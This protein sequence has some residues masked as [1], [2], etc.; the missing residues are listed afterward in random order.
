[1][2]DKASRQKN[3]RFRVPLCAAGVV[4][5]V[6]LLLPLSHDVAQAAPGDVALVSATASGGSGDDVSTRPSVSADGRYVAFESKASELLVPNTTGDQIFRKD[7]LSGEIVLVSCNASGVQGNANSSFCDISA[8]GRYVAFESDASNLVSP[9][10]C[11]RQVFRK[12]LATGEIKL[13]SCNLAGFSGNAD[14][15]SAS[16]SGDGRYVAFESDA[17]NLVTPATSGCQI[18]R[19][20]MLTGEVS[21]CSSDAYGAQGDGASFVPEVNADGRY[22]AFESDSTNLVTPTTSGRQ[23][24]RK[25]LQTG[26]AMLASC[27]M[28][29][30]QGDSASFW[31][32]ISGDGRFLAFTSLSTNLVSPPSAFRQI[33]RKDMETGEI[34]RA[35]CDAA[36]TPG[37]GDSNDASLSFDGRFA[38]FESYATNLAGGDAGINDV[39]RKDM[40]TGTVELCSANAAEQAANGA[41]FVADISGDGR[42]TAFSSHA[43]NLVSPLATGQQV[44]R[45]ELLAPTT[46]YFAEGYTGAGFQEYLCLGQPVD[47][48][49][50]VTVT[51]LFRDG[52]TRQETY[53]VPALSRFTVNV[54]GVVGA[55]ME[56]SLKCEAEFPFIA[57]RPM[58]F[59]YGG[60]G[61]HWTGGHDVMGASGSSYAWY[62]AEG[63]TGAGFDEW[64]CVLNPG[65]TAADLTFRFQTQE[66]GEKTVAGFSVP[67]HSRGSFKANDLLEGK[68]YQTSLKLES[69]QPVVAERPMYFAYSGTAG[70][71][72]TGVS[73][74][75]G[76][77]SLS[78]TYFFAEGTTRDGFEEWLTLQNPGSADINVHA[79]YQLGDGAPVEKDYHVPAGRRSTILVNSPE[80]GVGADKDVSVALTCP[81]PFLA[82]RPMYFDY[83][84]LGNWGWTGG[85]CVI[86]AP[87]H[88]T[89]WY[90]AEGYTGQGFEEWIC[91]QN[92]GTS[93]ADVTVTYYKQGGGAPIVKAQPP[94]PP[95]SRYTVP[96]NRDAGD[97]LAISAEVSSNQPIIAERPM[98]FNYDGKWSGGHDVVGYTP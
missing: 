7:L 59:D 75:M 63:Y 8:D 13:A 51:Y 35:S 64:V 46:F 44:Y 34:R 80:V 27:T 68:S 61:A 20:D 97:D 86:G 28:A 70:H 71:G 94:I 4:L 21:L 85:H 11:G 1:M 58:Y 32:C 42:Y 25:D 12:D 65:N 93:A 40:A 95:N 72:W 91:I 57:E 31:T 30:T 81:A 78:R 41:S 98:Y 6:L 49:L 10:T 36:G 3:R 45:K 16:I 18:F 79:I 92:P 17:I 76:A 87:R 24:F 56:V 19:K 73:C 67:A 33:L 62:F 74:V 48:P 60:G 29:G 50:D 53:N 66:E 55:D 14:S 89:E 38:A 2:K 9:S 43:Y 15:M 96:V 82:E 39:F 77:T 5:T 54:N 47:A 69:T 37:N 26:Q 84:G 23:V 90:F 52:T 88:A 22:V 83:R